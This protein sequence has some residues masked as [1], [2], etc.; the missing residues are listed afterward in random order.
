MSR[1][2]LRGEGDRFLID[3][4]RKGS[5]D[6]FRR[7]VERFGGRLKAFAARRLG[8]SGID[9]EDAVQETFLSLV[10][11]LDRLEE[12]RSLQAFLFTILR[13][14]IAD[15]ARARGPTAGAV[16]LH[17]AESSPGPDPASPVAT[18]STYARRDEAVVSRRLVLADVLEQ[19]LGRLK[20]ERKFRDLKILEL[21]FCRSVS[22]QEVARTV[23]TSEPTVSRT[24]KAL[25]EE[26][27]KLVAHHP[28]ADALV[29]LPR[30]DDVSRLISGIWQE[31]LFSCVKRSTL[32]SYA[33]GALDDEWTA[34]VKFH[35]DVVGCEVCAAHLE[36]VESP[37]EG[38]SPA[39]RER[40]YTSSVGFLKGR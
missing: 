28:R 5:S 22:H 15:L 36:D 8:G 29:D 18:P 1:D 14:R 2:T 24:R 23:G 33:L 30:G 32:G 9:P 20:H 11:N 21:I 35:L 25:V 6:A 34:Y 7:L 17:P 3:G 26:L 19:L 27:R 4:M 13:C 39:T 38:V 37:E 40:I 16:P 12:V 31:N 10:R